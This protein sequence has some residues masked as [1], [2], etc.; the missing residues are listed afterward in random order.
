[1]RKSVV[2]AHMKLKEFVDVAEDFYAAHSRYHSAICNDEYDVVDSEE[3]L[4]TE[5]KRIAN[6]TRTIK[7]WVLTMESGAI[8]KENEI[9]PTD[10]VSNIGKEPHLKV[11][12]SIASSRSKGGSS[13]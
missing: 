12:S 2:D 1:M 6:F 13:T 9:K 7:E 10:S 5:R 3:Y 11:R 8:L 4:M